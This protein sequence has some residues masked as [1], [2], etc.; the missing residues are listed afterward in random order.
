MKIQDI[1]QVGKLGLTVTWRGRNGQVRRILAIPK[2]P[3]TDR[4]LEVRDLL[5]QEARR[6]DALTDL[7]QDAWNV[8]ADGFKSRPSLGQSGPLTGLQLFVRINCKLGLLGQDAVDVPPTAPQFPAVAPQGLV[9]TNTS[10]V[11]AVKLTCAGNRW[12]RCA[13]T[14]LRKVQNEGRLYRMR[15]SRGIIF[16]PVPSGQAGRFRPGAR[17]T[18]TLLPLLLL[19]AKPAVVEAQFTY[20][21]N[22]GTITITGYTGPGGTVTIPST[23]TGLPVTSIGTNAFYWRTTLTNVTIPNGVTN[24]GDGAFTECYNLHGVTI[25]N[26][27]IQIGDGAFYAC[28]SLTNVTIP[29]N[30]TNIGAQAFYWCTTLTNATIGTNV[31][32]IGAEAF[33]VSSLTSVTLPNK[34][35]SISESLFDNCYNL[36]SV[37]IPKGVTSIGDYAFNN[38]PSLTSITIPNG[39]TNIGVYAFYDCTSLTSVTLGTNVMS[40]APYAFNNCLNLTRV[41]I[42]NSVRSIGVWAFANCPDVEGFYFE[43]NPPSVTYYAFAGDNGATLYYVP[44]TTGWDLASVVTGLPTA[45]WM[46]QVQTSDASFGVRTNRFGFNITWASGQTVVV[47][48]TTNL[49]KPTW[50]PLA[51]NI[52]TSGSSY[53]SDPQW[54]N[55]PARFYRLHSL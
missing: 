42:P 52:I 40:I 54:T 33:S 7:Q 18:M 8:A 44:G 31:T 35:T 19:F 38:C 4:Q 37:T 39:V 32:R 43:G 41:T 21:T 46:P 12:Q 36:T 29:N 10:G 34:V 49:A 25:P 15:K 1:P 48:G 24:I 30:V 50:V 16:E 23:I 13:D 5:L 17:W 47:E 53:F 26:S 3:R 55:Y 22:K 27:L 2:N 9:I 28:M 11:V 14:P 51:T 20:T 6:F 45:L